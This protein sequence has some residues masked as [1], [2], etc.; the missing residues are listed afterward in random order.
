MC[1]DMKQL[2]TNRKFLALGSIILICTIMLS[3]FIFLKEKAIINDLSDIYPYIDSYSVEY[4]SERGFGNDRFDIY[5]FKLKNRNKIDSFNL[6]DK[7]FRNEYAYFESMVENIKMNK[8][9]SNTN[10]REKL[11]NFISNK[12][13]KYFSKDFSGTK[14][15]YLY[16]EKMN[17]GY[18][19]IL[20]I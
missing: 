11:N 15:L 12:D 14:K 9:N 3:A 17:K 6:I 8:D 10:I 4:K 2:V 1:K 18:C 19:L 20:T 16:N 5:S 7:K 13:T